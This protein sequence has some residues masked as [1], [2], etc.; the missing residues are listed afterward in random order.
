MGEKISLQFNNICSADLGIWEKQDLLHPHHNEDPGAEVRGLFTTKCA[1]DWLPSW[2]D[3][4]LA[5]VFWLVEALLPT[6][7]TLAITSTGVLASPWPL[8]SPENSQNCQLQFF[9]FGERE[10][11]RQRD[12]LNHIFCIQRRKQFSYS[13][14]IW[15]TKHFPPTRAKSKQRKRWGDTLSM[16]W[17]SWSMP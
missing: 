2:S 4:V 9:W 13:S 16:V 7:T 12:R 1:H 14:P 17:Y 6:V 11:D 10:T 5:K 8:K 3:S 15:K